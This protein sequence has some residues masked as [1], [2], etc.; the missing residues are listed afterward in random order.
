MKIGR[1]IFYEVETGNVIINTGER[2]GSVIPST[3]EQDIATYKSLFERNRG[4]FDVIEL[5]FGQYA[6]DFAECNGYRVNPETKELEFSYPNP[7]EE[8]FQEPIYQKPLSEEV[9]NLKSQVLEMQNYIVNEQ[10][11]NL[12]STG[13]LK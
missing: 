5:E 11:N 3:I 2:Q 10:Y 7:S 1:K 8:E 9:K 4:S 13:G 6:Q 12:L